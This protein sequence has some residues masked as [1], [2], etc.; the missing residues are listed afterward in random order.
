VSSENSFIFIEFS[1]RERLRTISKRVGMPDFAWIQRSQKPVRRAPPE[2]FG[3]ID[4][5]VS[6]D[7]S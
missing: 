1:A 6:L 5:S 3:Y 7:E 2:R 4:F